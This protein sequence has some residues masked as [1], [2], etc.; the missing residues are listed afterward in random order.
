MISTQMIDK[1]QNW[2]NVI[3]SH[4]IQNDQQYYKLSDDVRQEE[5][6]GDMRRHEETRGDNVRRWQTMSEDVRQKETLGDDV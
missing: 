3:I 4:V 6:W 2:S 5:T 1:V